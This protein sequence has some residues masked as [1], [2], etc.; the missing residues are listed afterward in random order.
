MKKLVLSM[1]VILALFSVGSVFADEGYVGVA[2]PTNS[3]QRWNEDGAGIKTELEAIGYKVNLQYADNEVE[4]QINQIENMILDGVNALV[5][6]PVDSYALGEVLLTAFDNDVYVFVYDRL[7]METPSVSYALGFNNEQVGTL[8]GQYIVEQLDLENTDG[9]Y[10]IE[11]F[12]GSPDDSNAKLFY[13]GALD[14]LQP[15]L[16]NGKLVCLSGQTDFDTVSTMS[17]KAENAAARMDNLISGYYTDTTELD[18]ILSSNDSIA[19]GVTTS[20]VNAG[21]TNENFPI[22]TGQDCDIP[23]V[24]SIADGKQSM[25]VFKDIRFLGKQI[26]KM[27]DAAVKGE[28]VPVNGEYDNGQIMVPTYFFEPVSVTKDNYQ[29]LLIDSGFYTEDQ[30]T[31]N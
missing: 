13:K 5:I 11:F 29:E 3:L 16:D 15:Y 21:W 18:A 24:I 17:W 20:L 19:W 25:C 4:T 9:P 28:E 14:V 10:T 30:V 7:I 6:A 1:L 8:Q 23:N 12:S 22:L 31:N 2:M 26:V 27:V